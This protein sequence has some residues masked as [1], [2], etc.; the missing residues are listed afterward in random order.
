MFSARCIVV[1]GLFLRALNNEHIKSPDLS[2]MF[3]RLELPI[4]YSPSGDPCLT[5]IGCNIDISELLFC[6]A[7]ILDVWELIG[8]ITAMTGLRSLQ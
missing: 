7:K 5:S 6:Y 4:M 3:R 2:G 1:V 8:A